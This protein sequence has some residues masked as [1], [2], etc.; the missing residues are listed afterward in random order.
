MSVF[1]AN[2]LGVLAPAQVPGLDAAKITSGTFTAGQIPNLDAAKITTGTVADARLSGNIPWLNA[3][4]LFSGSNTVTGAFTGNGAGL[5]N[6]SVFVANLLGVLAPAQVPG[7]D[8]AKITSGTFTAGQIPSLDAAKI[9][10]GTLAVARIPSLDAAKI[11]TGT[12]TAG[13]IPNL[14]GAIITSGIVADARLSSNVPWLNGTNTFVGSNNFAG[15]AI[16]TNVANVF[17]GAFTGN[18]A[19]LTN[20]SAANLSGFISGS[21]ITAGSIGTVQLAANAV[22]AGNIANGAIGSTQLASGASAANLSAS[23]Q[24]AVASGGIVLSADPNAAN[25]LNVGYVKIGKADL[26]AEAWSSRASGSAPSVR[27]Y[28]TA[29]WTGSEM[30][31]WGGN[32]GGFSDLNDGG[33]YNPAANSWTAT[34]TTGAPSV[35]YYHT[36]VWT[37]SEMIVWGGYGGSYLGDTFSYTPP[38]TMYLY[39]KP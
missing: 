35:R 15:V 3:N 13:Q 26:A 7:L 36:A 30:I 20:V 6:V 25:L 33:R 24:S 22:Q 17:T 14:D 31:V 27:S 29:V 9:N 38:R 5:T 34:P 4:N 28:Y 37:G 18:G 8:A 16:I 39:L 12:F 2:L 1:V 21:Q 11:T 32:G 23:G 10:S 19:G